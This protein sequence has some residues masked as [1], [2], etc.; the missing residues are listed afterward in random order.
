MAETHVISALTDKRAELAGLIAY[1]RKEMERISEEV[2][3]LDATIKMFEPGYRINAIKKKRYQRKN[4]FFK[5]GE[6]SRT[7]LDM[8]REAGNP[9]STHELA[10]RVML[11]NNVDQ[12]REKAL[13]ATL[14]TCLHNHKKSGLVD[15]TGRDRTGSC[16]WELIV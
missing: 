6:A 15:M 13:Q 5:H 16:I 1:H 7:V 9:L 3:T 8:L 2:K 11:K 4:G 12:D 10:K 14:L